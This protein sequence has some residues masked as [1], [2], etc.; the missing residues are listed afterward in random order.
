MLEDLTAAD[1]RRLHGERCGMTLGQNW[2]ELQGNDW[3]NGLHRP[4]DRDPRFGDT[5]A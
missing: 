3:S 1:A 4:T 2:M 5:H